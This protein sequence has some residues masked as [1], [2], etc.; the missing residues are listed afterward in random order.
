MTVMG[1]SYDPALA[2]VVMEILGG[3]LRRAGSPD[4]AGE[5]VAEEIR[6]L[7]GARCLLLIQCFG[8]A[9]GKSPHRIIGINPERRR[10]WAEAPDT[11]QFYELVHGIPAA[12]LIRASD[13]SE[14]ADYLNGEGFGLSLI[15]PLCLGE[16]RSG[17]ILL[18][19]LPEEHN[20]TLVID[21]INNLSTIIAL[22]LQTAF[23][24]ERQ[25]LIIQERTKE[26]QDTNKQLEIELSGRREA[27]EQLRRH[28]DQL[29]ETVEQRTAELLLARDAAEAASKA[30]SAFLANM[31]HELRTPLNAILGF[32]SML[33]EEAHRTASQRKNI[34]IINHSG[35]HLLTLINDVLEFSRIEA[36]GVELEKTPFDLESM[37]RDAAELMRQRAQEK[38]LQLVFDQDPAAP[39]FINGD[40]TRLRE[41]LINLAGNAVKFTAQGCVTIRLGVQHDAGLHLLIEIEDTGPGISA[42]NQARL[43]KPFVQ[44]GETGVQHGTG[45]GLAIS[46]QYIEMMGG[47]LSVSS[48]EGA[49]SI[50]RIVLPVEIAAQASVSRPHEAAPDRVVTGLVPGHPDYRILIIGD[51][52][53]NLQLLTRLMIGIGLEVKTGNGAEGVAL[54]QEWK[55]HLILMDQCTPEMDAAEA[56]RRIRAMPGGQ[57]VKIAAFTA[58]EAGEQRQEPADAGMNDFVHKPYRIHE[59]YDCLARHLGVKFI[60][61]GTAPAPAAGPLTPEMLAVLPEMLRQRLRDALASLD[62]DCIMAA[63]GEA[64]KTDAGLSY[65]LS[66]LA[67][68]FDYPAILH[69]LDAVMVRG[70]QADEQ[71]RDTHFG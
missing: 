35:E 40:E 59:I 36:E 17:A 8:N 22:V 48:T 37:V 34:E 64:G 4:K 29:E 70:V 60:Y 20:F 42:E 51:T 62:G 50:F 61:S 54:F 3:V 21:L 13:G 41:V 14:I 71:V 39:R 16:A 30:K 25:E 7:T 45:L 49:G 24:F 32:S 10:A 52:P 2:L 33:L 38:G 67:E 66:R 11:H 55:P 47:T 15:V 18:L 57:D 28:K 43:F 5:Y 63:I 19:G 69:A 68:N 31:S 58:S 44:L 46:R 6:E 65:M 23:N 26:L 9:T 1:S 53:G 27:E 12:Q 56:A